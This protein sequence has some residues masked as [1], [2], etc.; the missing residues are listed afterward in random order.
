MEQVPDD[1]GRTFL[2]GYTG[3]NCEIDI[4]ECEVVPTIC[5]NVAYCA[6]LNGTFK[7][8]C[9]SD[10]SGNYFTGNDQLHYIIRLLC[11]CAAVP[12]L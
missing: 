12:S 8:Y 10:T 3:D 7:C 6:N 2:T 11:R 5:L 4:N 1:T 9:G